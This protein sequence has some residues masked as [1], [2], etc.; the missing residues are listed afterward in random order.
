MT[1]RILIFLLVASFCFFAFTFG[2]S[3]AD[4]TP[5]VTATFLLQTSSSDNT[6]TLSLGQSLPYS[7]S[8]ALSDL[9]VTFSEPGSLAITI[10]G[11]GG[12]TVSGNGVSYLRMIQLFQLFALPSLLRH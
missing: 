3:A 10:Y 1:R 2:V 12:S 6:L 5:S 8:C 11:A 7:I 9:S 4:S